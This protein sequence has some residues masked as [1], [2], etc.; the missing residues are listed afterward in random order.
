MRGARS[1]ALVVLFLIPPFLAEA[2]HIVGGELYYEDIGGGFYEITLVVYRD[3]GPTNTNGTYFDDFASVGVFNNGVLVENIQMDLFEADISEV[4]V[5]LENPCFVLPPDVCVEQAVYTETVNLPLTNGGYTLVYQRCCR[6]PSIVNLIDPDDTGATFTTQIP[7]PELATTNSNPQFNSFPPVALCAG[8]EFFFDHSASDLDG[9]S[10]VYSFCSPSLGGT[11]DSPAPNPPAGPPFIPVLWG[12]GFSATYPILSDPAFEIDSETGEITGTPTQVGQYVVG[13]CVA[14]YRDGVLLSTTNRDFQFNVTLCDP[15]II[16]AIP[17]QEQFCD[18]LTF[19]FSQTSVNATEFFWDFGEFDDDSDTSTDPS[20][21]YTYGDTGVYTVTLIANPGW[22]CADTATAEYSAYPTISPFIFQSDFFC[23]DGVGVYGFEAQ[24]EFDEDATFLWNFGDGS[25]P[26][27][28]TLQNPQNIT[29]GDNTELNISLSVLDNGCTVTVEETF[30]IPPPVDAII[31]PQTEFCG[32]LTFQFEQGSENATDF[33]WHFGLPGNDD[34]SSNI[35]PQFTYPDT[36]SYEVMLVASAF[37]ACPDTTFA[38]FD[39][40]WLLDPYFLAPDP[41]CFEGHAFSFQGEGTEE[42][43][44]EYSWTFGSDA[45]TS[46]QINPSGVTFDAPGTYD[47]TLSI[48]ANG[49]VD[50]YTAPVELIPNPTIA[51][52]G[53]RQGCP[54]LSVTFDNESFT[55]TTASYVWDFGDGQS[56]FAANPTHIYTLP[57]TYDVTLTMTTT[58]GCNVTLEETQFDIVTVFP[59]PNASFDVEPNTVNIL[60][61]Q[62]TVTNL[63]EESVDCFYNFGDGGTSTDCNPEYEYTAGGIFEIVQTVTNSYGCTDV[64]F[65]EV[66]VEGYTFYAPNAFTPD[67]DGINDV[68][69]PVV[70]GASAYLIEVYNR[71]GEVIFTSNDPNEPWIGNVKGGDH[72]AQDGQYVYRVILNDLL[73]LPHEFE[74]HVILLR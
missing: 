63:T 21:E 11:P 2:T 18:G 36:G 27:V 47:V 4:P 16:A 26:Q 39:I 46:N 68:W 31:T 44:A 69:K 3:C 72:Y 57:G 59:K 73:G 5:E 56:S 58:G 22:S 1:L 14:E 25:T 17:E 30:D 66:A 7:G 62:V 50:S 8:A 71:W 61:P 41:Q 20:P 29:F 37:G 13:V 12:P 10:L 24:G 52:E 53:G 67:Q 6:N 33:Q 38:T 19:Q 60:E 23:D 34:V 9:D 45:A 55:A 42:S 40:Y 43:T 51:F 48:S 70:T 28:S 15:T 64:A 54:N 65:G 32:G 74:G 49:C 35:S